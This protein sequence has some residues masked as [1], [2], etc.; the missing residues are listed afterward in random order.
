MRIRPPQTH[1]RN[2]PLVTSIVKG[3]MSAITAEQLNNMTSS[4]LAALNKLVANTLE[5]KVISDA[6]LLEKLRAKKTEADAA[7]PKRTLSAPLQKLNAWREFVLSHH[8]T[9]GWESYR[10]KEKLG[11]VLRWVVYPE[12]DV[13]EMKGEDGESL[14]CHVFK[15]SVSP[16]EPNGRQMT[17]GHAMQLCEAYY[18][19]KEKSGTKPELYEAFEAQYEAPA[20]SAPHV[21]VV[22]PKAEVMEEELTLAQKTAL[23]AQKKAD[24][25]AKA[26]AT[27]A[28]NKAVKE[29]EAA[30]SG[31]I[32]AKEPKKPAGIRTLSGAVVPKVPAVAPVVKSRPVI[33]KKAVWT[34]TEQEP[35]HWTHKGIKYLADADRC[36]WRITPDENI[37]WAG[38]YNL[39]TDAIDVVP[40]P[41]YA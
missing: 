34:I 17:L 28:A 2:P 9:Q 6:K 19:A 10:V 23:Q 14:P 21:K 35:Q 22:K 39:E 36:V 41:I 15:G 38:I 31:V 4:G 40:E 3:K 7:A 12:S 8:L 33:K 1:T 24:A 27:R 13:H 37:Q 16:A 18:S 29:A 11:G 26:K 5:K 25:L 32:V 30:A 20:A